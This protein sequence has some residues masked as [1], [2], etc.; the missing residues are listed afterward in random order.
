MGV[1]SLSQ[2]YTKEQKAHISMLDVCCLQVEA[3]SEVISEG[4]I[5]FEA[6]CVFSFSSHRSQTRAMN[7]SIAFKISQ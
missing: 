5:L 7:I 2:A 1:I 6:D 4:N 3:F